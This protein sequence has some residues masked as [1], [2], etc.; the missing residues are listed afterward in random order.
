MVG[1]PMDQA[2]L[3]HYLVSDASKYATGNV[4]RVNGGQSMVW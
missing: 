1:E 2:L 4:F 3:V